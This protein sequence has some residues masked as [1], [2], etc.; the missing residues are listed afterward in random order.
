MTCGVRHQFAT[1]PALR[2]MV[3]RVI[4]GGEWPLDVE[5]TVTSEEGVTV[6]DVAKGVT[7][8]C[9]SRLVVKYNVALTCVRPF[10]QFQ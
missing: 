7:G 2:E 6:W 8:L 3:I 5:I 1:S 4:S 9:V 10:S